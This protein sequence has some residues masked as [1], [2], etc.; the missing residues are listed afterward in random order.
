MMAKSKN[1]TNEPRATASGEVYINGM[2][3]KAISGV[4]SSGLKIKSIKK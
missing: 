2:K 1:I 4:N 3:V